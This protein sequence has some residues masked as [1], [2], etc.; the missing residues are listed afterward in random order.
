MQ[1][2]VEDFSNKMCSMDK[3][4]QRIV[5]EQRG[6]FCSSVSRHTHSLQA[7]AGSCSR[8]AVA[9]SSVTHV[10]AAELL[11]MS[12]YVYVLGYVFVFSLFTA[13]L[14]SYNHT[15]SAHAAHCFLVSVTSAVHRVSD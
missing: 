4:T 2:Y 7:A 12:A 1:E 13:H 11:L 9:T 8:H 14:H 10:T 3:V 5:K 15:V 6:S